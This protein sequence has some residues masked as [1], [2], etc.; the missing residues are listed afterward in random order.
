M[1]YPHVNMINGFS[2]YKVNDYPEWCTVYN[3]LTDKIN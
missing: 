2:N 3:T 1:P